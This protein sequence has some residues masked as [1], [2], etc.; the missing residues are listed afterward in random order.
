M[1]RK[2]PKIVATRAKRDKPKQKIEGELYPY[3]R[4]EKTKIE[5]LYEVISSACVKGYHFADNYYGLPFIEP[6]DIEEK[7]E[8]IYV[9]RFRCAPKYLHQVYF[10]RMSEEVCKTLESKLHFFHE[11]KTEWGLPYE[12]CVWVI[13]LGDAS[14]ETPTWRKIF[15]QTAQ[16][17]QEDNKPQIRKCSHERWE[18]FLQSHYKRSLLSVAKELGY[19][20]QNLDLLGCDPKDKEAKKRVYQKHKHLF[21]S[22]L[23]DAWNMAL[24]DGRNVLD[25]FKDLISAWIGEDLLVKALNEYGFN[26][27]LSNADSDRVIKTERRIITSEPD[28]KVEFE[29]NTRYL[30]LMMALSPVEKYGQIDL[31]L[32]KVKKQF[33]RK[34]LFLLYGLADA[35][36]ILIDFLRENVTVTCNFPN[37][38]YGNKPSSIL[39]FADNNIKMHEVSLFWETLKGILLNTR[40]EPEHYLK[41][42]DYQSG[43]ESILGAEGDESSSTEPKKLVETGVKIAQ[44]DEDPTTEGQ[45]NAESSPAVN[46]SEPEE[47]VSDTDAPNATQSDTSAPLP[48]DETPE[49][50]APEDVENDEDEDTTAYTAEQWAA[51]NE[52]F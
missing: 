1:N 22:F 6:T 41:M 9:I 43:E 44:E 35:K 27:S 28:I 30:E 31:R 18:D 39:R 24:V 50:D 51:L 10:G 46:V 19:S 14:P 11:Y 47:A 4:R 42:V 7:E 15:M 45:D 38:R 17:K 33:N 12:E 48:A 20:E 23:H 49:T 21:D 16:I 13:Q 8:N 5:K 40:P 2:R 52:G 25:Y 32:S 36:F 37:P 34:N 26:A 3:A 29:G